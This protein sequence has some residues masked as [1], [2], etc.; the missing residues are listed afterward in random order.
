MADDDDDVDDA[1][2]VIW[3]HECVLTMYVNAVLWNYLM[4]QY[5]LTK[6]TY[7]SSCVYGFGY[8]FP[9]IW[10]MGYF[11]IFLHTQ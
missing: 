10:G 7:F 5:Y 1:D 11:L 8:D 6:N 4:K 9:M 3:S 2:N